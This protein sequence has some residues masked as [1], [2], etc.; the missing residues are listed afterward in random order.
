MGRY[1]FEKGDD[2]E[3]RRYSYPRWREFAARPEVSTQHPSFEQT[4]LVRVL[5]RRSSGSCPTRSTESQ[6]NVGWVGQYPP[7]PRETRSR[8]VYVGRAAFP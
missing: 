2:A 1:R 6:A 5:I 4:G 3:M 7:T 8:Y